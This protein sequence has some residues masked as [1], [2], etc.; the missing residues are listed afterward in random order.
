MPPVIVTYTTTDPKAPAHM[1]CAAAILP[2]GREFPN[3]LTTAPT[4][5]AARA[6]LEAYYER[7]QHHYEARKPKPKKAAVVEDPG[8]VI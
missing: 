2:P 1:R 6:K 4:E 5:E 3:F 7:E 8:V